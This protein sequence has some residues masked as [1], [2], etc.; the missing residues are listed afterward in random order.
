M[1]AQTRRYPPPFWEAEWN[2][3]RIRIQTLLSKFK[4][5]VYIDGVEYDDCERGLALSSVIR[6]K[7][8]ADGEPHELRVHVGPIDGWMR[9][10]CHIFVDDELVGGDVT[11]KVAMP[12]AG[13]TLTFKGRKSEA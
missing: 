13:K 11:K 4:T 3:H 10:G 2:G 9:I 12:L 7:F 8:H 6:H 1:L 5:G